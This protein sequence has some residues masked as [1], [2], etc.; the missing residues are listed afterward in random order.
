MGG[1]DCWARTAREQAGEGLGAWSSRDFYTELR[2]FDFSYTD[3]E[4]IDG[5]VTEI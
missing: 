1:R 2:S 4:V 3:P 5:R